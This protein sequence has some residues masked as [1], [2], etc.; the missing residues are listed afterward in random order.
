MVMEQ[1]LQTNPT[2]PSV[3]QPETSMQPAAPVADRFLPTSILIAAVLISGSL[4][5]STH[6]GKG[7]GLPSDGSAIISGNNNAPAVTGN[8]S[9]PQPRD[10]ILGEENA[11]VTI[12]EY[13]DYQCPF[14]AKFFSGAEQ[15]IREEY[16]KTGKV[17]MIYREFAILGD[18]SEN[19]S[20]AAE[21]AKDQGKFWAYHDALFTTEHADGVEYN[22]NLNRDL[23][24]KLA[25]Q[26]K[27]DTAKFT[28]CY[29]E[30]PYAKEIANSRTHGQ[31]VGVTGTPS[32]FLDGTPVSGGA[33]AFSVYEALIEAQLAK[34]Q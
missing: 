5:Y 18:E 12:I 24:I 16:V 14:C 20:R 28:K 13:G 3:S 1:P 8:V 9:D 15:Q 31:A 32:I 11:P 33:N 7:N 10:V 29:D 21:C 4:V 23:F 25:G 6:M 34:K 22:G 27:L 17:K 2:E 30:N 19:A 26:T